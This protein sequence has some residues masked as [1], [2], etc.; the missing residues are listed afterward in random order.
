MFLQN[1]GIYWRVYMMPKPRRISSSSPLWKT[2]ISQPVQG[3][4]PDTVSTFGPEL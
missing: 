1:V 2:Q 3:L 4:Q